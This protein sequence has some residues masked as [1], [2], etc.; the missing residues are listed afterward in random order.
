MHTSG[1]QFLTVGY[2]LATQKLRSQDSSVGIVTRYRL[3]GSAKEILV[4]ARFSAPVHTG[5]E[6][7]QASYTMDTRSFPEVKQLWRGVDHKPASSAEVKE[8]V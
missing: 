1:T 2:A 3:D 5:S 8:R 7:H 4:W 6:A